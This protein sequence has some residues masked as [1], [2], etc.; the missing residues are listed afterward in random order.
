MMEKTWNAPLNDVFER[1]DVKGI[2]YNG[3]IWIALGYSEKHTLAWSSDGKSWNG[4]G[5]NI[6]TTAGYGVAWNGEMWVAVGQPNN[7]AY[8]M[9]GKNWTKTGPQNQIFG[10]RGSAIAYGNN[11]WVAV[12]QGSTTAAWSSDGK[13]WNGLGKNVF[14]KN[15]GNGIAWNGNLW[16]AVGYGIN[17]DNTTYSICYSSDGKKWIRVPKESQIFNRFGSDVAWNGKMWVAVGGDNPPSIAYSNDGINWKGVENTI[18]QEQQ[19]AGIAWSENN[20][21]WVAVGSGLGPGTSGNKKVPTIA[22]SSDGINWNNV[23]DSTNFFPIVAN[24]VASTLVLPFVPDSEPEPEPEPE[25]QPEPVEIIA[26]GKGTYGI[27]WSNDGIIWNTVE[28]SPYNPF[29][30]GEVYGIAYNGS[31]W[32]AVG[33]SQFNTMAWSYDGRNWNG[34]DKDIFPT[35]AASVAWSENY[36]L[37]VAVGSPP[38]NFSWSNDGFVWEPIQSNLF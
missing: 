31:M 29:K 28:D 1:G 34:L 37:W 38:N 4:L 24:G 33:Q 9:D 16:V 18:F 26:V 32:I 13:N 25:P 6:F 19:G 12:G 2:G 3:S 5:N 15:L 8:S 20:K 36:K 23:E 30:D 22:Y 21:L 27:A 7:F 11:L 17:T 14:N 35:F 10:D